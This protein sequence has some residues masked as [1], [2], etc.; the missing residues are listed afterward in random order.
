MSALVLAVRLLL[1]VVFGVAGVAKLLD[2]AGSRKSLV[3]FGLPE[4]L[5]KPLGLLLPVAELICAMA[6]I[7]DRSAQWGASGIAALLVAFIVGISVVLAQGRRPDCHCF[8][9]LHSTPVGSATLLRNVVLLALAGFALSQHQANPSA[10]VVR[11]LGR[12]GTFPSIL[13]AVALALAI[14]VALE[15]WFLVSLLRQNGRLLLR[16]EAIEAKLKIEPTAAPSL[17]LPA[18]TPAPD[19]FLKNLNG[20]TVT[21]GRLRESG[22]PVMLVFTG[23]NCGACDALLPQLAQWQTEHAERLTVALIAYGDAATNRAKT[24]PHGLNNVLLQTDREVWE[25]YLVASTPSAVLIV[26][27]LID[28]PVVAGGDAIRELIA[29]ATLPPPVAKGDRVPPLRLRDLRGEMIELAPL[30]GRRTMVLFWSPSCGF[31]DQMLDDLKKWERDRPR[32]APELLIISSGSAA[33]NRAQG[34]RSLVLLD[35]DSGAGSV[36]GSAGTPSAVLVDENGRIASDV[37]V[38]AAEVLA[39]AGAA[40]RKS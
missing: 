17:E 16:I 2:L 37:S 13:L 19:F 25:S 9:Q 20:D 18:G 14:A 34:L 11:D 29:R 23:P 7:P 32:D 5:A 40:P 38:G 28:S 4:F 12:L 1:A 36:L 3:N 6:L 15:L 35:H 8:G 21:L 22:K 33:A 10:D 30:E 31:C 26:N 27:G 24:A 39:L